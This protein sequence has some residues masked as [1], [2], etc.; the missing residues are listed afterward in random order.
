MWQRFLRRRS[1][2]I[3]EQQVIVAAEILA[4]NIGSEETIQVA[5]LQS[6]GFDE[7]QAERFV[8][9]LALAFSCPLLEK[10]GVAGFTATISVPTGNG[11]RFQVALDRQP[12]Y[13]AGLSLARE[14]D[15][16]QR[17]RPEVYK[18]I[19]ASNA[20]VAV[21]SKALNTGADVRGAKIA[22]ALIG[23]SKAKHVVR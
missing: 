18:A 14:Q 4:A 8:A 1:A 11:S 17:L 7:G 22:A 2:E 16:S 10:L 9:F 20:Y 15:R 12:E 21:V 13:V 3:T 6:A 19:V 5:A 23:P